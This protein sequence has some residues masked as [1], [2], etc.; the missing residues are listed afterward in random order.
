MEIDKM[1][2]ETKRLS[3]SNQAIKNIIN[4][5]KN[6]QKTRNMRMKPD[7]VTDSLTEELLKV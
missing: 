2:D 7:L 5:N 1:K 4:I 6:M 3:R